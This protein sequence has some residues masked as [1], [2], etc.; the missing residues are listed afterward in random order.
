MK[1]GV[2][3]AKCDIRYED[4]PIPEV[5][6]GKVLIKVTKTKKNTQITYI[7][8][9]WLQIIGKEG[10]C[11]RIFSYICDEKCGWRICL[12]QSTLRLSNCCVCA[13]G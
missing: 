11:S 6:P 9:I 7:F 4:I 1:A 2:V 8:D 10:S 12:K 3:H 5:T 13:S